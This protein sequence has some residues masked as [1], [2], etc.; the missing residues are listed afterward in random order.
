MRIFRSLSE[1]PK[2]ARNTT[3]SIGNFDGVHEGHKLLF[4]R[5]IAFSRQH[6]WIPSVLTFDPHPTRV[7]APERAPRLLTTIDQRLEL[8]AIAGIEQAFVLPFD[9]AFS[10]LSP[11]DFVG[12][13]LVDGIG[14][15]AVLV[16][17]NFRFGARQ[18]GD[19]RTLKEL[20]AEFGFLTETVSAVSVRGR[21]A[22]ST[23]IRSL[24]TSGRVSAACRLLGRPY[25]LDGSV[26][27]G[28]GVGSKQTVPTLNLETSAEVLPAEGVYV[29]RT[30]DLTD[31]RSW[32]SVTNVGHRPTFNG[33]TLS[34][35]TYLLEPLEGA[36]PVRIGVEFLHRLR[37]EKR[38]DSPADLKQQIMKDVD[39]AQSWFRRLVAFGTAR[40]T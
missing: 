25:R 9:R 26:V 32:S 3:V 33:D 31:G 20:G 17:D 15:R 38:F 30:H 35:E 23:E 24:I 19:V 12:T 11:R 7:V 8:M 22:S 2:D 27:R 28:R 4:K 18:A 34:I 40:Q 5:N 21:V 16:G 36:T 37:G 39:R 6:G 13:V 10:Q 14:T 1:I 29:T